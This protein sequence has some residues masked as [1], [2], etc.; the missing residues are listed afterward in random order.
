[1]S[2]FPMTPV[3]CNTG[4]LIGLARVQMADLPSRLFPEV[5]IPAEVREELLATDSPDRIQDGVDTLR[6]IQS[7]KS[8]IG[9]SALM[10]DQNHRRNSIDPV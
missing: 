6:S 8:G 3:V 5:I 4:P 10:V 9:D 1:M 2:S 7:S